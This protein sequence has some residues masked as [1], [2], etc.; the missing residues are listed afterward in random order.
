MS[1]DSSDTIGTVRFKGCDSGISGVLFVWFSKGRGGWRGSGFCDWW[2]DEGLESEIDIWRF[3]ED[4]VD[5]GFC[6]RLEF[7]FGRFKRGSE[8]LS[9]DLVEDP[10]NI[11]M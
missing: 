1:L 9:E 11:P 10:K 3:G 8:F 5:W 2:F 7:E 4:F 6:G